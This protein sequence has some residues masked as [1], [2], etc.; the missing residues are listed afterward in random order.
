MAKLLNDDSIETITTLND[1]DYVNVIKEDTGEIQKIPV[2]NLKHEINA[3]VKIYAGLI[4]QG[5]TSD[6]TINITVNTT[7]A[8]VSAAR[9]N[10]GS[11]QLTF[12][13]NILTVGLTLCFFTNSTDDVVGAARSGT[14]TIDIRTSADDILTL[15]SFKIEIYS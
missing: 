15:C 11:Y 1:S 6:P 2:L 9:I 14:N 4:D 8:I 3:G 13:E 7:G 10:P 5:G 12:S